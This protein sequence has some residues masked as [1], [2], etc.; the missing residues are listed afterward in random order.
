MN[1]RDDFPKIDSALNISADGDNGDEIVFIVPRNEN[2]LILGGCAEA[3]QW[4]L[5]L[6]LDT[7]I[8]RRMLTRCQEF[9]PALQN[10]RLDANYPLA[11]GLRPFRTRNVRVEREL[12]Q[13]AD[14]PSR[15]IHSY[16]QGGAGWSLSFGCARDVALLVD[17]ALKDLTPQAMC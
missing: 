11:Q 1:D 12:R 16:G 13:L 8:V 9:L 5:D 10:A 6:S 17:E 2:I 15:I 14:K 4:D 3:N 7:P